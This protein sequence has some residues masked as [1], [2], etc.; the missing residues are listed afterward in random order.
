MRYTTDKH[1]GLSD[2]LR[3]HYLDVVYR[4]PWSDLPVVADANHMNAW[5]PASSPERLGKMANCLASFR[6][7][8]ADA[9]FKWCLDLDWLHDE[10]YLPE[11]YDFEWPTA[12]YR[13]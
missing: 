13:R 5:G 6:S 9:D 11:G 3:R 12:R 7:P 10:V 1:E 2:Q 8:S 4:T